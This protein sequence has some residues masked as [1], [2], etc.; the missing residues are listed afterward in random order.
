M[1]QFKF[2]TSNRLEILAA[3]LAE[4]LKYP[5]KSPLEKEIIVVQSKGMQRWISMELARYHGIAANI[6]FLFPNEFVDESFRKVMPEL[7]EKSVY[8]RQTMTW[9]MM[10]L[11]PPCIKESGFESLR[12][13]FGGTREPLRR[14]Q[15][16]ERI[17]ERFDQYL[18]FRPEMIARWEKSKENHWQAQLW[19]ELRKAGKE[20]HRA[21]LLKT[22][23]EKIS[24]N[25]SLGS[26][27]QLHYGFSNTKFQFPDRISVFG[28]SALP[29]FH[30]QVLDAVS[31]FTQVNLFL[32]N[33]CEGYW[34]DI[35]SNREKRR[36]TAKSRAAGIS[37]EDLHLEG[38]N[39]LLASMGMLG[40][41]FFDV[42][43]EVVSEEYPIFEEP[44]EDTLL[45]HIQSDIMNLRERGGEE[46]RKVVISD[47][48]DSVQIHSCHSPMREIE[49]LHDRLLDMFER[50]TELSPG[51]VL[52]MTPDIELYAPY[53]QAVFDLPLTDP[54]R[55]P[56]SI[57]DRSIRT[58]SRIADTF[59]SL[60]ELT[61]SRFGAAQVF[62]ILEV[63]AVYQ[64]FDLSAHDLDL[65][66]KWI[67]DTRIRWGIDGN[68]RKTLGL[69]DFR[70]N[71]WEAGL[72]RLLLGY[73]LPER[74]ERM[75]E[76]IL[77]YDF[78]EGSESLVLG[79]FLEFA[80]RLFSQIQQMGTPHTL[81][82]WA[83]MMKG[84][85]DGFFKTDDD[86]EE[87]I[88]HIRSKLNELAEMQHLSG[89]NEKLDIT[90]MKC[91][92]GNYFKNELSR[93]GF[94]TGGV[95][96][97]AMLPM[98]S[99]PFKIICLA[100]MGT[101]DYPRQSK[102]PG[103]DLISKSPRRGD[104]SRR[105]D[106]RYLFLESL[107]SA[108]KVLYISFVGQS[109]RDNSMIPPSV[110]VSELTDYIKK[111]FE[112]EGKN[113]EDCII[114]KHRLQGFSPEYFREKNRP[115][116]KFK[117]GTLFSYSHENL[118]AARS[119][120]KARKDSAPFISQCLS[121]PEPEWK[122]I[123]LDDFY[124]FFSNPA[125][126]L[127]NRRLSIYLEEKD[128]VLEEKEAF[129]T[130][131][132]DNYM[133]QQDLLEKMLEGGDTE[134]LFRLKNALGLLPHGTVGECVYEKLCQEVK[135]F[136]KKIRSYIEKPRLEPLEVELNVNGFSLNGRIDAVYPERLFHYRY[137]TVKS[138]DHLKLWIHHLTLNCGGFLPN[139]YPRVSTI[140]GSDGLWE[141]KPLKNSEAI[142]ENL[143]EIYWEGLKKPVHFF[144]KTSWEYAN[145]AIK[146][147]SQD[148]LKTAQVA[149]NGNDFKKSNKKGEKDDFYFQLCFGQTNPLDSEFEETAMKVFQPILENQK[150]LSFYEN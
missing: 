147:D 92:L 111:G 58:E 72:E 128:S 28:I 7:P 138:K 36:L 46:Y 131:W 41:D 43:H 53:I 112:I 44:A 109:I 8:D 34:G 51:D 82:E 81:T 87:E 116:K 103:F 137:A 86:A 2:F 16:S 115:P 106:D 113:I 139:K 78:I 29:R 98:R 9:Q 136:V 108:R 11:L 117:A 144:P 13:Y 90:V 124:N 45:C 1:K 101:E 150:K 142:L 132:L 122:T 149:W 15:L 25:P 91:C 30:I 38:G 77:P 133:I 96:F 74:E 6:C 141:Y 23:F 126:F 119:L 68:S 79:K 114:T 83:D 94:I 48:D 10:R 129:E 85:L 57:A 39:S 35:L 64:K 12:N 61:G 19:R 73:A 5:L 105:N 143:L 121:E 75:F 104:P 26:Q 140:A 146:K 56:F 52:V 59:M 24:Q 110:L 125:K 120:L 93:F 20:K 32:M 148:S 18:I 66:R 88:Q 99:I 118:E 69:P 84:M 80:D 62:S 4:I 60:L 65:I 40:R 67:Q 70:E 14:F 127:L 97:C 55:I 100:G 76:G 134:E 17:A 145:K 63:P 33:P 123:Q 71:T 130:D 3:E 47:N 21:E 37:G 89:F 49:V 95:T 102:P 107:L 50:D 135:G 27:L 22:F 31:R 54:R 42:I